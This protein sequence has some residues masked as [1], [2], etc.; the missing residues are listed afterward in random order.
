MTKITE[1]SPHRQSAELAKALALA[2]AKVKAVPHDSRNEFHKYAYT[3]AEAIIREGKDALTAAG[4]ALVSQG[5]SL[6]TIE[7][8]VELSRQFLLMH[9]SS[10]ESLTITTAWPVV[11]DKGR[12]LDKAT[13]SAATTSL[14]Y[15]LR[16]LL[17]MPR[18]DPADD[19]AGRED[20][21]QRM[22]VPTRARAL[23]N[24]S[25]DR[26]EPA[27]RE[28]TIGLEGASRLTALALEKKA[29]LAKYLEPLLGRGGHCEDLTPEQARHVWRQ[30]QALPEPAGNGQGRR[31]EPKGEPA[32]M[33]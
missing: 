12:P 33:G 18:V 8:H 29:T 24:R 20:R 3:S 4:L 5:Q 31:Q 15:L 11:P 6:A 26:S 21:P 16:D 25:E 19:L 9:T 14:A 7:G 23:A 22:A 13:A 10:G 17:L 30:L 2:Q 27:D 28:K 1:P 32:G